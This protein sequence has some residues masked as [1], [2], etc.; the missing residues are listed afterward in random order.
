MSS[1]ASD[2]QDKYYSLFNHYLDPILILNPADGIIVGVN[3]AAI[4]FL[5]RRREALV[6]QHL[7]ALLAEGSQMSS[8]ELM[9][10]IRVFGNA[11]TEWNLALGAGETA[12]TGLQATSFSFDSGQAILL[13][14][15]GPATDGTEAGESTALQHLRDQYQRVQNLTH[16]LTNPLQEL[17]SMIEF[18]GVEQYRKPIERIA[19]TMQH[20]RAIDIEKAE[21]RTERPNAEPVL[22]NDN[23]VPCSRKRVLIVDD[24]LNIRNLFNNILSLGLPGVTLD[25]ATNGREAIASFEAR[26][27]ELILMDYMMP[28]MTGERVA[29]SIEEHCRLKFWQ[30]PTVIMCTGYNPGD[31]L[32]K[33]RTRHLPHSYL[34]KPVSR[35][36]LVTTVQEKLMCAG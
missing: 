2:Q 23:R 20:L 1:I 15:A 9:E 3:E 10:Q 35:K 31:V 25:M 18:H 21:V 12:Q 13:R 22:N 17:V 11:K 34:L 14:L 6:G 30:M 33:L 4:R 29:R 19:N 8:S 24:E 32:S 26:H 5:Q 27:H 7:S 28:Q 36:Q 16:E